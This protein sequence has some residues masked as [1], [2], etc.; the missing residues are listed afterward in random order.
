VRL[1]I[2]QDTNVID[3]DLLTSRDFDFEV[4]GVLAAGEDGIGCVGAFDVGRA[5]CGG[6]VEEPEVSVVANWMGEPE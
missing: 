2:S 5:G 4:E 3:I 6:L 1:G